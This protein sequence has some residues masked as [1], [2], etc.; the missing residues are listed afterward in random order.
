MNCSR[1]QSLMFNEFG[2]IRCYA[3]GHRHYDQIESPLVVNPNRPWLPGTCKLCREKARGLEPYCRPC[4]G[5]LIKA[6]M[7]EKMRR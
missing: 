7:S 4:K 3:C 5:L 6:G 2:E 1:C